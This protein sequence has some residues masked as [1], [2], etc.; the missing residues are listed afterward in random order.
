MYAG[1]TWYNDDYYCNYYHYRYDYRTTTSTTTTTTT[2]T[3]YDY[4]DDKDDGCC[5]CSHG[6][7]IDLMVL[8]YAERQQPNT[9]SRSADIW[10]EAQYSISR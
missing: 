6:I 3:T 2:T 5:C 10:A 1:T 4:D 7:S 9:S 8:S